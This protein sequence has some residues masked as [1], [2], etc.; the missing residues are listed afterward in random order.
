MKTS[1]KSEV[2]P[3]GLGNKSAI[4]AGELQKLL[5]GDPRAI[6]A[7]DTPECEWSY[8]CQT[9]FGDT[10]DADFRAIIY[11][12]LPALDKKRWLETYLPVA[13]HC[14]TIW[15]EKNEGLVKQIG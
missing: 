6:L 4:V 5:E 9:R 14:V 7:S 11:S 8:V 12:P 2:C 1:I 3:W 13:V 10:T 15:M